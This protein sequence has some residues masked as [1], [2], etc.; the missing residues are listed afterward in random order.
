M[1]SKTVFSIVL[2]A[3]ASCL[4]IQAQTVSPEAARAKALD[5]FNNG[6]KNLPT[7]NGV[8]R[9]APRVRNVEL[10]YTSEKDG[11]TCFYVY[12]N[13]ENG[14]FVIVGGDEVAKEILAYVPQGHFDYEKAPDN[15]KWWLGQYE[16]EIDT[17]IIINTKVPLSIP[18]KT[19]VNSSW[20]DIPD[21]ITTKWN[22][23]TPYNNAIPCIVVD[24]NPVHSPT[25]CVPTALAQIMNY[26][27]YP[28]HG[29]GSKSYATTY[30][31]IDQTISFSADFEN[32]TYDWNNMKDTYVDGQ[33]TQEE[34]QA[35]STLMYHIGVALGVSYGQYETGYSSSD[36][37]S[38]YNGT[39]GLMCDLPEYFGYDEGL[40]KIGREDFTLDQWKTL[41][42]NELSAG[43][44][45]YYSGTGDK[46]GHAFV[47]HG[48]SSDLD[49]FSF[50]W[51]WG[52]LEDGYFAL[53]GTNAVNGFSAD[54][55]EMLIGIRPRGYNS[56]ISEL[57]FGDKFMY[58]G[59]WYKVWDERNKEVE[60]T[61]TQI[62]D[63]WG[64]PTYDDDYGN[65]L[66]GDV[67]IPSVVHYNGVDYT[68]S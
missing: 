27:Q 20:T 50:N 15:V 49:M 54:H 58:D 48:Y 30:T 13:G 1:K 60:V 37:I 25:G 4:T 29:I 24:D 17:A 45:V 6:A 67:N 51:G 38:E 63:V 34:A 33:Y 47:C 59:I 40:Q 9:A 42:Y 68:V 62:V 44:P 46:G 10:A 52:G 65:Y 7:E 21:M 28:L 36:N 66:S 43:R 55:E 23:G 32:T 35:V 18:K 41:L 12:N 57:T 26:W 3:I 31:D 56:G 53:S 16:N 14:G 39:L 8:R 5:F 22:Q 61:H 64:S 19:A 11:K 2:F